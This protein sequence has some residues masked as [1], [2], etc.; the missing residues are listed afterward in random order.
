[1]FANKTLTDLRSH[2]HFPNMRNFPYT[3]PCNLTTGGTAN[4][5]G[6]PNPERYVPMG[7][8]GVTI[9]TGVDLGQK[10]KD[11]LFCGRGHTGQACAA[12]LQGL[13]EN[14]PGRDADRK[15]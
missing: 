14:A 13:C 2:L 9:G 6:G 7:V 4:Y 5:T 12:G 1:S 8:S 11:E 3:T 15:G 10:D